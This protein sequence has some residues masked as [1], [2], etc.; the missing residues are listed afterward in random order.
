MYL[1]TVARSLGRPPCGGLGAITACGDAGKG[2]LIDCWKQAEKTLGTSL[3]QVQL[4]R[5]S[6]A[7]QRLTRPN[8]LAGW[9]FNGRKMV[10]KASG[11]G[12]DVAPPDPLTIMR[13]A[14]GTNKQIV[15]Q[16]LVNFPPVIPQVS[17]DTL[18]QAAQL[19][20]APGTVKAAA[21]QI[22]PQQAGIGSGIGDFL[23]GQWIGGV[24]N[25]LLL[26]GGFVLLMLLG[27]RKR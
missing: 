10:W 5:V 17:A 9:T 4:N 24:P 22:A 3:D 8:S 18:I 7:Y 13:T 23:T 16:I 15:P 2:L 12:D 25:Y 1:T 11:L 6:T 19:P 27:R 20:G 21:A 14:G 26:G